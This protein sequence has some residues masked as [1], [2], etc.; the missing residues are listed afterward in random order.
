MRFLARKTPLDH[1]VLDVRLQIVKHLVEIARPAV[2]HCLK[3][4][5]RCGGEQG[6]ARRIGGGKMLLAGRDHLHRV[7]ITRE[8]G[9]CCL[10]VGQRAS[11]LIEVVI[12]V[13]HAVVPEMIAVEV[14]CVRRE[15]LDCLFE[16]GA[17]TRARRVVVG[18]CKLAVQFRRALLCGDGFELRDDLL[19]F[20][21]LVPNLALFEQCHTVLRFV[22]P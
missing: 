10:E 20:F 17:I 11:L 22:N 14:I 5:D 12:G 21:V 6:L 16:I 8:R 19:K 3:L 7:C 13:P 4:S 9:K 1:A 18:A 15:E 2:V